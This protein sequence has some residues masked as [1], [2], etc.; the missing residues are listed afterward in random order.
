MIPSSEACLSQEKAVI[1]EDA[2]FNVG[3]DF[4]KY[5]EHSFQSDVEDIF[6]EPSVEPACLSHDRQPLSGQRPGDPGP[7]LCEP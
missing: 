1:K 5:L 6:T 7:A 3:E 4:S 2:Y